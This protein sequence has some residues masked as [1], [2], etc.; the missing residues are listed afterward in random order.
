VGL[1][2]LPSL[3]SF[4]DS[5]LDAAHKAELLERIRLAAAAR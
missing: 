3:A 1:A 4:G 2:F 5:L